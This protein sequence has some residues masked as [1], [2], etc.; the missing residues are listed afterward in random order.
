MK[1]Y[2]IIGIGSALLD[3]TFEVG[4]SVLE[5][6]NLGKG[7]MHLVDS[8]KSKLII[9]K[10]KDHESKVSPGGSAANVAAGVAILG[11]E[12]ALI[13]MVGNDNH[14]EAYDQKTKDIGV[15]TMLSKNLEEATGKAITF[16]TADG[17]RT[18]AT[19]LGASVYFR[20]DDIS[21]EDIKASKILH[22]EAFQLEDPELRD[23]SLHAMETAKK[24][25]VK[26]SLDLA[27]SGL[28]NRCKKDLKMIVKNYVNIVFANED[29]AFAFTGKE[30]REALDLIYDM[31]D[32]AIVK[33][34]KK[35]SLIKARRKVYEISSNKVVEI[36]TNGA[37]DA[38]AAGI[39][40]SI[41]KGI[42]VKKA[43]RIASY[44]SGQVVASQGAR[45][46]K[47]LVDEIKNV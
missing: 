17:E 44:I 10:L 35:G 40:Y 34:G 46:E 15:Y 20:K 2:D 32:V 11:G 8:E 28:I 38:Y 36:N 9:G 41:A 22:I 26:I 42:G 6:F 47:S 16:T 12:A 37:G 33:L 43:G 27:D 31:C 14:G 30:G 7:N 45:L 5:D 18:F 3:I 24:N 1:R 4:D 19:Y 25:N 23:A 13:G 39:L 21:E 29:E